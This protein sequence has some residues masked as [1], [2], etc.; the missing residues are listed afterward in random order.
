LVVG[1]P[2]EGAVWA[3]RSLTA[4]GV[5]LPVRVYRADPAAGA[6]AGSP[7]ITRRP[8]VLHLHGGGWVVGNEVSAGWWCTEVAARLDAVVVSVGY[9]LA[10]EHRAPTAALDCFAVLRLLGEHP[11]LLGTDPGRTAVMGDSAGGNLAAAVALM[12]RDAGGPPLAAQVLV[13][14]ATDATLASPSLQRLE[15]APVL[16]LA[17]IRAYREHY[18]GP[19]GDDRDPRVS[20]LLAPSHAGLPPALIQTAEQDP[21]VDDGRRYAEALRH[22]DVPVRYTEYVGVPHGFLSMPGMTRSA[23]QARTEIVAFLAE[24]LSTG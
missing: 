11:D 5:P 21:L 20:P 7:P 14:P 1:R 9:R 2:A 12:A 24:W 6:L 19:G 8:L 18:L 22:A 3:D 10:P 4:D 17:D 15:H 16:D 23:T 13:Y